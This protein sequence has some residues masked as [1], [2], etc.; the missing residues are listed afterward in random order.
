MADLTRQ[1]ESLVKPGCIS[2]NVDARGTRVHLTPETFR[3][4][5]YSWTTH[6]WLQESFYPFAA[7]H[8]ADGCQFF[9]LIKADELDRWGIETVP[10]T[11]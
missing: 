10:A 1:I 8:E 5:F 6:P 4:L 9:C 2:V 3:S 7:I 11:A